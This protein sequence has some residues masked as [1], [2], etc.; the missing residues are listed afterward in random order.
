MSDGGAFD[1]A[2]WARFIREDDFDAAGAYV[3]ACLRAG[4]ATAVREIAD[5]YRTL[6]EDRGWVLLADLNPTLGDREASISFYDDLYADESVPSQHRGLAVAGLATLQAPGY[7]DK[8][9]AELRA[10]S[11]E[12]RVSALHALARRGTEAC[13]EPVTERVKV[14]LRRPAFDVRDNRYRGELL[15]AFVA[16]L[17]CAERQQLMRFAELLRMRQAYLSGVEFSWLRDLWPGCIDEPLHAPIPEPDMARVLAWT[18]GEVQVD[19][20]GWVHE[21]EELRVRDP[22]DVD[23][24]VVDRT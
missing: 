22:W 8:L 14:V 4:G 20:R 24:P 2:T 5:F 19:L 6:G 21:P 1:G 3:S 23:P 16:V 9:V 7:E 13:V 15:P 12:R 17:R 18:R 10:P 11:E